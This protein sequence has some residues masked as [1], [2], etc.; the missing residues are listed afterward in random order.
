[1]LRSPLNESAA[2]SKTFKAF[3]AAVTRSQGRGRLPG[4]IKHKAAS[5]P[6]PIAEPFGWLM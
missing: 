3:S 1:M 5:A 6:V 4:P 2:D